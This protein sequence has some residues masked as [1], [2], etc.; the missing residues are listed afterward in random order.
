MSDAAIAAQLH[1][2]FCDDVRHEADGRMSLMGWHSPRMPMPSSGPL[3]LPKLCAVVEILRPGLEPIKKLRVSLRLN[4]SVIHQLEPTQNVLADMQGDT[5]RDAQ[6]SGIKGL[7]FKFTLQLLFFRVE[8]P[9]I[10]RAYAEIDDEPELES[11]GL[12]FF[13]A[14]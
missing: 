9:G 7:A 5:L 4:D 3:V 12:A 8:E 1:C 11:R 10:L 13:R 6:M 2:I 14:G